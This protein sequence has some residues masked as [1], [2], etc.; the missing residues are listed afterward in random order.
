[1]KNKSNIAVHDPW[2]EVGL[3]LAATEAQK[4]IPGRPTHQDYHNRFT[5]QNLGLLLPSKSCFSSRVAVCTDM[6]FHFT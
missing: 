6:L 5:C 1:L 2:V 3:G 4:K